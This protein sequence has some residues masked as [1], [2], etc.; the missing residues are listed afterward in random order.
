M[1]PD[2]ELQADVQDELLWETRVERAGEIAVFAREGT[3]TLRGTVGSLGAKRAA[4]KAAQRVAGVRRID[5]KLD[6]RLLTEHRRE[7]AELRGE[8]LRALSWNIEV[9]DGV[10]ATVADGV[11]TLTG[12]VAFRH[13]RDAA[14]DAVHNLRGVTAIH[15][16]IKVKSP[17]IQADVTGR[18]ERAFERNAQIEA[19]AL[20]VEAIDGTVTLTGNV[21]SWVEHDAA[22]DA[23][24]AAPGVTEVND[25]LEI[26]Y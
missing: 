20:S 21:A 4:T 7:D 12:V 25:E 10:D 8:V 19:D 22:L 11:V 23:A 18:I 24:W 15:D 5:N 14:A 26:G 6:V 13:Q 1:K 17:V 9:P 2:D 3:V 16:E